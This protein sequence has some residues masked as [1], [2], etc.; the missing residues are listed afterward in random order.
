MALENTGNDPVNALGQL[1]EGIIGDIQQSII[2]TYA[3]ALSPV[4][5]M[6]RGMRSQPKYRDMPFGQ[7]I[8]EASAR[9]EAGK[10]N[11][12]ASQKPLV[13]TGVMLKSVTAKVDSE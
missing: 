4:T 7:L 3:P 6:L 12:G 10:T 1:G 11:Y 8:K 13:D 5:V 2:D 9:V